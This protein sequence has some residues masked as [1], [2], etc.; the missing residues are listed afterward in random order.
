MYN[1]CIGSTSVMYRLENLI[2]NGNDDYALSYLNKIQQHFSIVEE[3]LDQNKIN[4][5]CHLLFQLSNL[6]SNY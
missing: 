5:Q 3:Y 2:I 6:K 1:L 4:V